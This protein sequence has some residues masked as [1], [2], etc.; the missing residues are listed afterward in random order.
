MKT[1]NFG[2]FLCL[3]FL[4]LSCIFNAF[5]RSPGQRVVTPGTM[6]V[7]F[8]QKFPIISGFYR[9][10]RGYH[11]P[12]PHLIWPKIAQYS[13]FCFPQNGGVLPSLH[14]PKWGS[15]G[16]FPR[17][18]SPKMGEPVRIYPLFALPQNGGHLLYIARGDDQII[19]SL[20]EWW[21]RWSPSS[22][23]KTCRHWQPSQN[24]HNSQPQ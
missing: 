8:F 9:P 11:K 22:P 6:E 5:Q 2:S 16:L 21:R 12:L 20:S 13:L 10:Y 23:L 1:G 17:L 19:R 3:H 18:H 7:T 15:V 14:P 4:A 24:D